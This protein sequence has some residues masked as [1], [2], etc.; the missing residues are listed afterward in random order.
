MDIRKV[1]RTARELTQSPGVLVERHKLVLQYGNRLDVPGEHV[2]TDLRK[3]YKGEFM[4]TA[5]LPTLKKITQEKI[6]RPI[7]IH[8]MNEGGDAPFYGYVENNKDNAVIKIK[9]KLNICW[10]R[11]TVAK[12]LLHLYAD[13]CNDSPSATAE[14]LVKAARES[15]D[16]IVHDNTELD[17]ETSAFYM[18]L[19]VLIPWDLREQFNELRNLGATRYQIAKV[20]MLPEPFV[21]HFISSS[22]DSYASLSRRLNQNI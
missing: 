22:E 14:L 17:D 12:E 11:F 2:L 1:L 13:T 21:D 19:E 20:F 16:V 9:P 8:E 3:R 4:A 6:G 7:F 10:K 5:V 18:A 15:R